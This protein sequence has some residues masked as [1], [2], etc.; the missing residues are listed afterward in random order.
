MALRDYRGSARSTYTTVA[1]G[2]NDMLIQTE[3]LT[4]W[5]DG[6]PGPFF[7]VINRQKSNEEKILCVS[8]NGTDLV[9]VPLEDGQSGRGAD[10]TAP[11]NHAVGSVVEH[12][13]TATDAREA[14]LHVNDHTA[15]IDQ[16]PSGDRPE[17]DLFP[18]QMYYDTETEILWIWSANGYWHASTAHPQLLENLDM[19]NQYRIVNLVDPVDA[20]DGVTKSYLEGRIPELTGDDVELAKAWAIKMDGTVDGT[21][22]SSKYHAT[23]AA[24]DAADAAASELAAAGSATLAG[25]YAAST[26]ALWE[27]FDKRYLGAKPNAPTTDNEGLP[28]ETGALYFNTTDSQM[29]VWDGSQWIVA[30]SA[31]INTFDQFEWTATAGQTVFTTP[32]DMNPT[33]LQVYVNGVMVSKTDYTAAVRSVTLLEPAMA[34]DLVQ[35]HSF[36]EATI[37]SSVITSQDVDYVKVLPFEAWPVPDPDDR[38][39]YVVLPEPGEDYGTLW[40][41]SIQIGGAGGSGGLEGSPPAPI[42]VVW[43][44]DD[45]AN[46]GYRKLTWESGG[47]GDAG[48]TIGYGVLP[49]N[50]A[51]K[52]TTIDQGG[53]QKNLW[54]II[55]GTE[56]GVVY[57]YEVFAANLAGPGERAASPPRE[58][59]GP[60]A[61]T[62]VRSTADAFVLTWD[63]NGQSQ[64]ASD[65]AVTNYEVDQNV[66]TRISTTINVS[67]KTAT[68]DPNDYSPGQNYKFRVRAQSL[69]G[70]GEWSE[71][72]VREFQV[73]PA[74]TNVRVVGTT[75]MWDYDDIDTGPVTEWHL[76]QSHPAQSSPPNGGTPETVT[77]GTFGPVTTV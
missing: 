7:V 58:F 17:T 19:Q 71:E 26:A 32:K 36:Q 46:S 60:A 65:G 74:P 69:S 37:L 25:Q 9:V 55:T 16:G 18:G 49:A 76:D 11:Q 12:I 62:N 59:P 51:A 24:S 34:G 64:I 5:P 6:D 50:E 48:P 61:P 20:Q 2:P 23:N 47:M 54:A 41:G 10:E 53:D 75:L 8:H 38:T 21:D 67:G 39:L 4:G 35:V 66:L 33:M 70:W 14:N 27:D 15:H 72:F 13:I 3:G 22:Y 56:P 44:S 1:L 43:E 68:L 31:A 63:H 29:Y 42:K 30:S 73:P 28:L 40:L 45:P 57:E 77:D 52:Q